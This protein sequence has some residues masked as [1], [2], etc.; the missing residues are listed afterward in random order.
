M[1]ICGMFS[2]IKCE[3]RNKTDREKKNE[4]FSGNESEKERENSKYERN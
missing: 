4:N 3:E 1:C 2:Q